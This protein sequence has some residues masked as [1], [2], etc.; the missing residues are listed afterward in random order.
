MDYAQPQPPHYGQH[1]HAPHM[2]AAFTNAQQNQGPSTITSPP[3]QPQ[4]MHQQHPN[5]ASPV[6]PSQGG[7]YSY[8]PQPGSQPNHALNYP[9]AYAV[10][11]PN[12][13]NAAAMATAAAAG[14]SY[15]YL[16]QTSMAQGSPRMAT[17]GIKNEVQ[18]RSPTQ[19]QNQMGSLPSQVQ[20]NHR[21]S[22]S[23]MAHHV[24]SPHTQNSNS[25]LL[26]HMPPRGSVP[27]QM[28]PP[29]PH[30]PSPDTAPAAVEEA[31]LYVNAKQF[32]R[33][34]KRRVARQKLEEALRLTS[35]GR[36]P[37]LH[38]SRHKH[39]MRR[40][41]GPGGRFLTAEEVSAIEKGEGGEL[42]KY[43]SNL[44]KPEANSP[45]E[46]KTPKTGSKRKAGDD[47]EDTPAKKIKG[48]SNKKSSSPDDDDEDGDDDEDADDE[49]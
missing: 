31:P 10:P 34:L 13:Q 49:E 47:D 26:N 18:R 14:N 32:H 16:P 42:Q 9:Q 23:Q 24:S 11:Q 17:M 7:N 2:Q 5:Q 22:Q 29:A 39:A 35:K 37:Y 6:L 20:H 38:E 30:Q 3:N 4:Q 8:P 21:M 12:M 43:A 15:Q 1:P 27:P 28:P 33:I 19:M 44:P 46:N 40:P 45:A 25:V 36:K 41:R 48:D